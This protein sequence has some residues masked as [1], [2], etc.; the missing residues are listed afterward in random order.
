MGAQTK[1]IKKLNAYSWVNEASLK[2]LQTGEFDLMTFW[3]RQ[4]IMEMV[5]D[6]GV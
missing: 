6:E 4:K 2:M 3:K 1:D 5:K